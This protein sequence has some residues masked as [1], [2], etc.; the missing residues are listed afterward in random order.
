MVQVSKQFLRHHAQI[1]EVAR[2]VL[3]GVPPLVVA[4]GFLFLLRAELSGTATELPALPFLY[5]WFLL[6]LIAL[7]C[8]PLIY[9]GYKKG[10]ARWGAVANVT[11]AVTAIG[12]LIAGA[13]TGFPA[14][15]AMAYGSVLILN[16]CLTLGLAGRARE[17]REAFMLRILI[18]S[19]TWFFSVVAAALVLLVAA[20]FR[21]IEIWEERNLVKCC[22]LLSGT[23]YFAMIAALEFFLAIPS[24]LRDST[25]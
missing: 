16:K 1:P 20:R 7:W 8:M 11:I 17:L 4:V 6:E 18:S 15:A 10:G 3:A 5:G 9:L 22:L 13:T 14:L 12:L 19:A 23:I 2:Y 24:R 21:G 25:T